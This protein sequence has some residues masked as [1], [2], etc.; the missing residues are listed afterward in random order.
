MKNYRHCINFFVSGCCIPL[1]KNIKQN[2]IAAN[3]GVCTV[4]GI[5]SLAKCEAWQG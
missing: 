4:A 1:S 3:V 2:A 5:G